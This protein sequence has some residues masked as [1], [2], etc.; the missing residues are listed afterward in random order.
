MLGRGAQAIR[1]A[2]QRA[3][4][5]MQAAQVRPVTYVSGQDNENY[6]AGEARRFELPIEFSIAYHGLRRAASF[7]VGRFVGRFIG[8]SWART[9]V[10]HSAEDVE[11]SLWPARVRIIP[12]VEECIECFE[13]KRLFLSSIDAISYAPSYRRLTYLVDPVRVEGDI[14]LDLRHRFKWSLISPHRVA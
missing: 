9:I 11:I 6:E 5:I 2:L 10:Y 8:R 3:M 7:C 12:F 13:D 14:I 4:V 1:E